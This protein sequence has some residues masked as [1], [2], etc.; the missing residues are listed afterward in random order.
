MREFLRTKG[1]RM[2]PQ[3]ELVFKTFFGAERHVS[4]DELYEMICQKDSSIGYATVW[5]NLKLICELGLAEEVTVGDGIT[6]YAQVTQRPQ[7]HFYCGDCRY[8]VELD[9][10]DIVPLVRERA[11]AAGL[12]P[13]TIRIELQ[14]RCESCP[15]DNS[16]P[17]MQR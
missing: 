16:L 11:R 12:V 15:F 5:R 6:R 4:L 7:A 1:L 8:F 9:A 3:R 2:T 13:H 17:E 10:T 14:G